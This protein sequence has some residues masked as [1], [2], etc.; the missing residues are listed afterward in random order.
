MPSESQPNLVLNDDT[1]LC[2]ECR[3]AQLEEAHKHVDLADHMVVGSTDALPCKW[4][5]HEVQR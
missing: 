5:G 2:Q 4:C 1:V 3:E